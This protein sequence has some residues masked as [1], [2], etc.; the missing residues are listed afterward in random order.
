[1][2]GKVKKWLGIEGVKLELELPEDVRQENGVVE[3][4][5]LFT[6]MHDQLVKK[7]KIIIIER[8]SRG[9]RKQKRI[10]E[11]K[12]G[13]IELNQ[14][15]VVKKNEKTIISFELP[16]ERIKSD[17]DELEDKNFLFKGLVQ[18]AKF[19]KGASSVFIIEA[20]ADV[21]GVALNPFDKQELKLS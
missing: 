17:M 5:I 15:I 9:R 10:D 20:E 7:I 1:M 3:G 2:L 13:E 18:T 14:E 21:A 19:I 6:S 16:F 11:Y 4:R 12:M 8:Y